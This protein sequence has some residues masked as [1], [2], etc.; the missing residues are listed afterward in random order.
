[1]HYCSLDDLQLAIP[2]R[3]LA[4]LSNDTPPAT[5][6]NM[7]VVERAVEHAEEVIDGYLRGRYE[8]PLKEVPTVVRELAVSIARHWLYARRPEGKDDLPPAVVRG[9]K[10]AMEMLAAMQKG[11]LTIGVTA[12]QGAQPE[13]GKMRV[14]VSGVRQF[15]PDLLRKYW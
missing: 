7:A 8:L 12:T 1:M 9:Y 4:Q 14:R 2:A 13:P 10:A 15:T 11:S 3:T 5:D 6:P